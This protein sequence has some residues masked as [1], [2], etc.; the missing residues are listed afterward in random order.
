M[1]LNLGCGKDLLDGF[2]NIDIA[3]SHPQVLNCDASSLGFIPNDSVDEIVAKDVLEHM[4]FETACSA[5]SEWARVLKPGG[6]LL[7]QTISLNLQIKAFLSNVW[8]VASFNHML[9][10]GVNW[11]DSSPNQHDFHKSAFTVETLTELL[12]KQG[13]TVVQTESDQID[14]VL[15]QN[16][17]AHNLNMRISAVKE[18]GRVHL[19]AEER[20]GSKSF[21]D[22]RNRTPRCDFTNNDIRVGDIY[23]PWYYIR[24]DE[25]GSRVDVPNSCLVYRV[26]D[27]VLETGS[28][29]VSSFIE[30]CRTEAH[31][32]YF[33]QDLAD[34]IQR[35][36][37]LEPIICVKH[38][39]ANAPVQLNFLDGSR[40]EDL[41]CF[42]GHHRL[43]TMERLGI[44]IKAKIYQL[45][46]IQ[47][48]SNLKDHFYSKFDSTFWSSFQTEETKAPSFT[49]ESFAAPQTSQKYHSLSK[50]F[51]FIRELKIPLTCG[52]D[53]GCA[54]GLY[55]V[56]AADA[57][58]IRMRG[59]D[60]EAGRVLRALIARLHYKFKNVDYLNTKWLS[61]DI[62]SQYKEYDFC[63]ALSI[64]HHVEDFRNFVKLI[65]ENKKAMIIEAR[66]KQA[67]QEINSGSMI[68]FQSYDEFM[69]M[70]DNSGFKYQLIDKGGPE[71]DRHFFVFWR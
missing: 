49:F 68:A 17:L 23:K 13:L 14:G 22:D 65:S 71:G 18:A 69:D 44:P 63:M 39:T 26:D 27:K 6:R 59:I 36:G 57:F 29:H 1:K 51:A 31:D 25:T 53:I 62:V 24:C 9:F 10:A 50:C 20:G 48:G 64:L 21:I 37:Q 33:R 16:P 40:V 15:T 41:R 3:L 7:L 61:G 34:S 2:I 12:K 4:P 35:V 30:K 52:I 42:E 56:M 45:Y 38:Y 5:L 43:V 66:L 19:Q 28:I 32:R 46:D 67:Q 60:M 8:N 54:E 55:S 11:H 58:G 70:A 47:D